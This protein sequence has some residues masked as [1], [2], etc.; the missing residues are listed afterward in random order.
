MV[1]PPLE[2]S[3]CATISSPVPSNPV[4]VILTKVVPFSPGKKR[5][6]TSL[7]DSGSHSTSILL[8]SSN[9][10]T[11]TVV[12]APYIPHSHRTSAP[13]SSSPLLSV[14]QNLVVT[15]G[16][17][18]AWNTS[19][20]GLRKIAVDQPEE[21]ALPVRLQCHL[22]R[23]G[24][25]WDADLFVLVAPR[26][27]RATGRRDFHERPAHEVRS[28]RV[29]LVAQV[30]LVVHAAGARVH[31]GLLAQPPRQLLRVGEEPEHGLRAG[32]DA[33]LL[34]HRLS[35]R[36]PSHGPSSFPPTPL[37]RVAPPTARPRTIPG[38]PAGR[39]NPLGARGTGG[40]CRPYAR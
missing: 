40:E 3:A 13:G 10:F 17:T 15:S 28:V 7:G 24:A 27:H 5:H 37:R 1:N 19:P 6:S 12:E 9:S 31:G 39:R 36:R 34:H 4:S 16:S 38:T 18:N 33:H 35:S 32:P 30:P 23:A 2:S 11:L 14:N 25:G 21:R 29:V 8:P 26:E 22:Q 20:T